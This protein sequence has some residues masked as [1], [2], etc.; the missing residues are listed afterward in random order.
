MNTRTLTILAAAIAVTAVS[1]T[2]PASAISL[3]TAGQTVTQSLD[4]PIIEVG[5]KW[6]GKKHGNKW[7]GKHGKHFQFGFYPSYGHGYGPGYG[8]GYGYGGCFQKVK[9][10]VS[11]YY[12]W[13]TI[14][15]CN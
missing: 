12:V 1:F 6:H 4:K 7:H 2:A 5:N 15:L 14:N 3:G 9:A 11:G 10:W 13:T 8:H